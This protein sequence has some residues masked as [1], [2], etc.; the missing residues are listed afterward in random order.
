MDPKSIVILACQL[1][2]V[3]TVLGFGLHASRNDLLYLWRRPGLLV[4]SIVSVMLIM[5]A[6]ALAMESLF[7]F[8]RTAELALVALAFSPIPP[9]L[10][11]KSDR[12][13]GE[14]AYMVSLLLTLSLVAI[15]AVPV[16][17]AILSV[18]FERQFNLSVSAVA[19][20]VL[21]MA[22]LPLVVGVLIRRRMPRFADHIA[23][24]VGRIAKILLP[25]A[26]IVLLA[27]AWRGIWDA[28]GD[29]TILAIVVFVGIGMAVG[30]LLG[31][32]DRGHSIGLALASSCRHPAIALTMAS[33]N[34]PDQHFAGTILLY[35]LVSAL[36]GL[37][38][39]MYM[40]RCEAPAAAPKT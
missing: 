1:S 31:R 11:T 34:F 12:A 32:P 4:R 24:M 14:H 30:H 23:P 15:V 3:C 36:M 37:P 29:G 26:V 28:I 22:V 10:P 2:I 38:Y 25:L 18:V 5:P 21:V 7:E 19:K 20:I 35:V 16:S 40:H 6:V 39:V 27:A 17:A 33:A 8:R 9:L 13:G